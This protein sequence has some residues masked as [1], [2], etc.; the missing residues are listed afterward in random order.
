MISQPDKKGLIAWMPSYLG[1]AKKAI[2]AKVIT[3]FPGNLNSTLDTH[4][5]AILLFETEGGRLL[6]AVDATSVTA[7]RT[8]AVSAVATRALARAEAT[9]LAILGSGTQARSHLNAML[10]ARR[11]TKVRLW[12]RN[13]EH[14]QRFLDRWLSS[15]HES[16]SKY[17]ETPEIQILPSVKEAVED[18]DIICTTTSTTQPILEGR[19]IPNGAHINAVGAYTPS[20]RELDSVAVARSLL[21]VD[22]RESAMK[23]AGDFLIPKNEGAI[24]DSHIRGELGEVLEG[25]VRGR[26][27]DADVT[28]FKSLGLATE[29]LAAAQ[30]IYEKALSRSIG[31][32]LEFS[33]ERE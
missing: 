7:I 10:L 6:A 4:Q 24:T 16:S 14:A 28:V 33:G 19:W 9:E 20:T 3:V 13:P 26:T 29:D 5:G 15:R 18:A 1:A 31:T 32:W 22:S 11:I 17:P 23:E 25:K 12:S 2:G 30:Y 27:S 21:F 8:A